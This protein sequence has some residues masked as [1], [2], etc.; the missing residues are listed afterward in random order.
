MKKNKLMKIGCI[1][2]ASATALVA[3]TSTTQ[4][5]LSTTNINTAISTN[6]QSATETVAT[7]SNTNVDAEK[8]SIPTFDQFTKMP[9]YDG[10]FVEYNKVKLQNNY[11]LEVFARNN[12]SKEVKYGTGFMGMAETYTFHQNLVHTWSRTKSNV[13][14]INPNATF[15][16]LAGLPKNNTPKSLT[17]DSNGVSFKTKTNWYWCV[18]YTPGNGSSNASHPHN[19]H[20]PIEKQYLEG[21][22]F[23]DY[24]YYYKFNDNKLLDCDYWNEPTT[25]SLKF[26]DYKYSFLTKNESE[27]TYNKLLKIDEDKTFKGFQSDNFGLE[28][29]D[30]YIKSLFVMSLGAAKA[31]ELLNNATAAQKKDENFLAIIQALVNGKIVDTSSP[32]LKKLGITYNDCGGLDNTF[33]SWWN[34]YVNDVPVASFLDNLQQTKY[35]SYAAKNNIVINDPYLAFKLNNLLLNQIG[36]SDE[37]F[38]GLEFRVYFSDSNNVN[39][40]AD[41][42]IKFDGAAKKFFVFTKHGNKYERGFQSSTPTTLGQKHTSTYIQNIKLITNSDAQNFSHYQEEANIGFVDSHNQVRIPRAV[43]SSDGLVHSNDK[44]STIQIQNEFDIT[45]LIS[46][47]TDWSVAE[48]EQ[49][50][51]SALTD[52]E[53]KNPSILFNDKDFKAKLLM[54]REPTTRSVITKEMPVQIV[55]KDLAKWVNEASGDSLLD[56]DRLKE[57]IDYVNINTYDSVN[58]IGIDIKFKNITADGELEKSS[59]A[60]TVDPKTKNLKVSRFQTQFTDGKAID[61]I[62]NETVIDDCKVTQNEPIEDI[63]LRLINYNNSNDNNKLLTTNLFKEDWKA[64]SLVSIKPYTQNDLNILKGTIEFNDKSNAQ[65]FLNAS[66][67]FGHK[68][69]SS[70][71]KALEYTINLSKQ[72]ATLTPVSSVETQSNIGLYVGLGVGIPLFFIVLGGI[73]LYKKKHNKN[74]I[75][76]DDD[77]ED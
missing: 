14:I 38:A 43:I 48:L 19:T 71:A 62:E 16:E 32:I 42:Q 59:R 64:N 44:N 29:N 40:Q 76:D 75:I 47:K 34:K 33:T 67:V 24:G 10:S 68:N 55:D 3:A 50:K 2:G 54:F 65:E 9:W 30:D 58:G 39:N 70:G 61:N 63:V 7:Y 73:L 4:A 17:I 51:G 49:L 22:N 8:N 13:N 60:I 66:D 45:K 28:A 57:L 21:I 12:A 56:N 15:E 20:G 25:I 41:I 74:A 53:L 46:I 35:A 77:D 18:S 5:I 31:N 6:K 37:Y 1:V 52:E 11:N 26:N 27:F 36:N 69:A 23:N 72:S